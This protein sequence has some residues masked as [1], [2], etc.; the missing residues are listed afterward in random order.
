LDYLASTGQGGKVGKYRVK[1]TFTH[2]GHRNEKV[3][4]SVLVTPSF[5][6]DQEKRREKK[7]KP[8]VNAS[9]RGRALFRFVWDNIEV[10]IHED[11]E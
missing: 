4:A 5:S 3:A 2:Y 9:P 11:H 8:R 1:D 10:C 6:E 7:I